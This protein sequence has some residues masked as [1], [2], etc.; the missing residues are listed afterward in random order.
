MQERP[1]RGATLQVR[2]FGAI[3]RKNQDPGR[4]GLKKEECADSEGDTGKS[5]G[6][7]KSDI[8]SSFCGRHREGPQSIGKSRRSGNGGKFSK[9][10]LGGKKERNRQNPSIKANGSTRK[11]K[12]VRK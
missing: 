1:K 5:V 12:K 10:L 11:P 3:S 6:K 9:I 4:G 7:K 2:A 8:N